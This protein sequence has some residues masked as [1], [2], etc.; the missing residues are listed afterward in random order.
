MRNIDFPWVPEDNKQL[1]FLT[2]SSYFIVLIVYC[3]TQ[4]LY[5]PTY[6]FGRISSEICK[7]Q[8][9]TIQ[10]N[11]ILD[12]ALPVLDTPVWTKTFKCVKNLVFLCSNQLYKCTCLIVGWSKWQLHLFS[13]NRPSGPI[14]FM[15]KN[16]SVFVCPPHFLTPFNCLF[17][18]TSQSPMPKLFIFLESLG[19]STGKMWSEI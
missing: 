13:K 3:R 4:C 17:A 15:S 12:M 11:T 2:Q 9:N 19:K 16:V 6:G 5:L 7:D 14:L 8:Y 1:C 10:Y 18:T